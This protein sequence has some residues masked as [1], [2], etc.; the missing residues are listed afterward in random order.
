MKLSY[1]KFNNKNILIGITGGIAIYKV[2]DLVRKLV[3]FSSNVKCIMTESATK[4]ISPKLFEQLSENKV[5]TDMFSPVSTGEYS[6]VHISLSDWADVII[7][8]PCSC[9]T[10]SRLATGKTEDL[11]SCTIYAFDYKNKPVILCPSMNSNMWEHPVTQQNVSILKKIGYKILPPESG[12][13]LCKK[14][15]AGRLPDIDKILEFV[16]K[17]L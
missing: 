3:N 1:T 8:V 13:L 17:F 15:G 2:C 16:Q 5:Y 11:L 14:T 9:N 4:L 12:K 7:V 10:L 6:P